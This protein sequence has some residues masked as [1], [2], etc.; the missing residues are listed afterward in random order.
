MREGMG[1]RHVC[2]RYNASNLFRYLQK[3][4]SS[5]GI[6][7]IFKHDI[8]YGTPSGFLYYNIPP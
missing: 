5:A 8:H 2:S 4:I 3:G 1:Q 6:M 7:T